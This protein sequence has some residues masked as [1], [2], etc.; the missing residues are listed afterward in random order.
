MFRFNLVHSWFLHRQ[1]PVEALLETGESEL[2]LLFKLRDNVI[3]HLVAP[4]HV[5][6]NILNRE[7]LRPEIRE[8]PE[9]EYE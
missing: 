4:L 3:D 5:S 8:S 7:L 9:H 2:D 6:S 1:S